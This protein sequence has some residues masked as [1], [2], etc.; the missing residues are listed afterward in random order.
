MTCAGPAPSSGSA[1]PET[2][3]HFAGGSTAVSLEL[4]TTATDLA[5]AEPTWTLAT[6]GLAA[7]PNPAPETVTE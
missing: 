5:R 2:W 6:F 7:E 3:S 1:S 4:L